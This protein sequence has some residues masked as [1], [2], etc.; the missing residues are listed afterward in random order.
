MLT[1]YYGV[2][3]DG[4]CCDIQK[5]GTPYGLQQMEV[6]SLDL[7]SEH[8]YPLKLMCYPTPQTGIEI[9]VIYDKTT[10]KNHRPKFNFKRERCC[11]KLVDTN[12]LPVV[13]SGSLRMKFSDVLV[14]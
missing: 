11:Y 12:N 14:L 10:Y 5:F 2:S 9:A 6:C 4:S 8:T 1:H 7:S 13:A 3:F